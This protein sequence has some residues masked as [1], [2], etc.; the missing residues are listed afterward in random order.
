MLIK[1]TPL[2]LIITLILC[3][4]IS[5]CESKD[6]WEE[7]AY[8]VGSYE[9]ILKRSDSNSIYRGMLYEYGIGVEADIAKA[10]EIYASHP[11]RKI[12]N[13]RLFHL[14]FIHC[15]SELGDL[16]E[17][18]KNDFIGVDFLF[19]VYLLSDGNRCD[20]IVGGDMCRLATESFDYIQTQDPYYFLGL[21]MY[22]GIIKKSKGFTHYEMPH[23]LVLKSASLGNSEAQTF[24]DELPNSI[25]WVPKP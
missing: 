22:Q 11:N 12:S 24:L 8:R 25:S 19:S 23:Y 10:R 20:E 9:H 5:S 7:I 17:S 15:E 18:I 13:K 6:D 3:F 2:A 1:N 14:C 16:Y 21:P 4:S